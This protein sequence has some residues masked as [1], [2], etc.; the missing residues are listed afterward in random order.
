MK[1][2]EGCWYIACM[3]DCP[4][5]GEIY[6]LSSDSEFLNAYDPFEDVKD[7]EHIMYCKMCMNEFIVNVLHRC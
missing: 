6:D 3:V 1:N 2:A 4:H 7:I 5:C